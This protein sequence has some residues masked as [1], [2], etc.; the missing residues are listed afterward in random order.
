MEMSV[1]DN[2]SLDFIS[3]KIGDGYIA[4]VWAGT[5]SGRSLITVGSESSEIPPGKAAV[6][7]N[8]SQDA[9]WA[10]EFI[11]PPPALDLDETISGQGQDVK[12]VDLS[13]GEWVVEISI[14]GNSRC[15][16]VLDSCSEAYFTIEIGGDDVVFEDADTWS[17]KKLV[18]VGS[19]YDE[20]PPGRTPIEVEAE[21]SA[22]WTLKFARATA[23]SFL[24]SDETISGR[25]TDVRFVD[26]PVGEWIV[27]MSVSDNGSLDFI[28][29]KIGDGYVASVWA[30]TWSGR[31][32]ITVG[33]ESSEIPP[34]KA[35]VEINVSQDASWALEF[36][37]PPPALDLDET[38]SGQGQDVK[39]VDLSAGEW[40]VEI[41][42][43]G[44]SRCYAV[45]DSCS[46]AYFTIEI[47]GDDV[48]FEDADTWSGK[49]L[50]TV[51]SAYDE[52]PPGRTAIEVEAESSAAWTL[53]F[54][55][56]QDYD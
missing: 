49:K 54:V 39:F 41:S 52:I 45:L 37:E 33:S 42:I 20:I 16:A 1:S 40:V 19:A 10:L 15:Y 51:G 46:E 53:K 27:E 21:S 17:G 23:L 43:S 48:V 12:F 26:L 47:G 4:S 28:S 38:I 30:G 31:S 18:A 11:E 32:L 35:A 7:I 25:G 22:T 8:V 29:I 44:N 55:R 2:G 5:W 6:E 13:A 36:I 50:V 34:G 24:A 3:I 56:Q 9:S 14:S